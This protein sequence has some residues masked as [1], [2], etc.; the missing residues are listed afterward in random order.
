MQMEPEDL[1]LL[2]SAKHVL[3]NPG[4]AARIA[5]AIGKPIEKLM[6]CLPGVLSKS[7]TAA[8]KKSLETSFVAVLLTLDK[9]KKATSKDWLHKVLVSV[10][11]AGGGMLGSAALPIE[12]PVS[13]TIM[14]RS[15]A[16]IARSEGE[17]LHSPGAKLAC[18]EV[19]ALAG[20]S[21]EDAGAGYYGVRANLAGA[22]SAAARFIAERG[23]VSKEGAPVVVRVISQI[24]SRFSVSVSE[25]VA[26]Q[27]IPVIGAAGGAVLNLLFIDHFQNI[28]RAHFTI[29][30]LERQYGEECVQVA[31][32]KL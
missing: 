32:S 8:A 3:D 17:D 4:L 15:I 23:F 28:A 26:A 1:E 31:Y 24:A 18:L 21:P 14:L 22:I 25:K 10:T 12:L 7:V 11:G 16:D 13:T 19:F 20:R 27:A 29:R 9:G 2:R 6:A 5:S 30:R